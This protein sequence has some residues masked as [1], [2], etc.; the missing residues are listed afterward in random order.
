MFVCSF[1]RSC[2]YICVSVMMSVMLS[3]CQEYSG[4]SMNPA[5]SLGPA[6]VINN[7]TNHWVSSKYL[8]TN[9][10]SGLQTE[11]KTA[12]RPDIAT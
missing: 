4:A 10:G 6:F 2:S 12:T 1:A 7:W 3:V 8:Y 11:W 9:R 5:R